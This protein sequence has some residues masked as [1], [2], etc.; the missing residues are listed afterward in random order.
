[1]GRHS[2]G[3]ATASGAMR[4]ELS[5][6]LKKGY[7]KK[8]CIITGTLSWNNDSRIS[9]ESC[10]TESQKY[11]RLVYTTTYHNTGG[12]KDFDYKIYFTTIP[13]NLGK[14]EVVYFICP[15]TGRKARI[16]YK[17]YG[18]DTWK[19]RFAYKNRIYYYSQTQ[20]RHDYHNS[21]YW[22]IDKELEKLYS[23]NKKKKYRGMKTNWLKR[24]NRLEAKQEE[25]D[26]LRWTVI[27]KSM[28]KAI[29]E[30]G[31]QVGEFRG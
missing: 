19:S 6:L 15:S 13:S 7:I 17:C 31:F 4:I 23:Q 27:T 20:S 30:M 16:L 8:D 29:H 26:F 18:S 1:M 12:K 24:A 2:T 11:I 3:S 10:Y 22:E 25:H 21:R 14:G 28:E 5:F 9:I